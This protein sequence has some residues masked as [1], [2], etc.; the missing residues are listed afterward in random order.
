MEFVIPSP[1]LVPF[2]MRALKMV[3]MANGEFEVRERAMLEAAQRMFGTS[4]DI[5]ALEPITPAELAD[6][7]DAP[8]LRK[9]LVYAMLVMSMADGDAAK[10]EAALVESFRDGLGVDADEVETFHKLS[11]G[12]FLSARFDVMRRFWARERIVD[13][14]K[15][16]G[17]GWVVRA[18]AALA[19]IK[20]DDAMAAKYHG[21]KEYAEG[22][23][24]RAYYDFITGNEF[25][26]P[27]EKGSPPEVI[28]LHDLTH[29]LG[30]YGTDSASE[31]QVTAFHAGYRK[32]NPFT[33]ILFSMMQFN[34]GIRMTPI[35][36]SDELQFDPPKVLDALRRGAAMNADLTDGTWDFRADMKLPIAEVRNKFGIPPKNVP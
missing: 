25:Q 23:L 30:G 11:E 1:E 31:I 22:T 3:A 18:V 7:I 12:H 19:K 33:W 13:E 10:E 36:E 34:M 15:K 29:V 17:F 32:K 21:L 35:A 27:G 2:G 20:T 28:I 5:D 8:A 9:Q 16:N 14:A 6:A 4:I 24:G 26:F